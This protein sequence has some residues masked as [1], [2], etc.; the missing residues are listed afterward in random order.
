MKCKE[1]AFD[2]SVNESAKEFIDEQIDFNPK[3]LE[4]IETI[5]DI[6]I[7]WKGEK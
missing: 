2:E 4:D 7:N 6:L 3:T 5:R 1:K